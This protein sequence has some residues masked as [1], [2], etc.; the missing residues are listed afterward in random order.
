M[1]RAEELRAE[2]KALEEETK[3]YRELQKAREIALCAFKAERSNWEWECRPKSHTEWMSKEV[4]DGCNVTRR[5]KEVQL[6]AFLDH[7]AG[8]RKIPGKA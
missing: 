3:Q 6:A 8:L 1:S 7:G 5:M 2:L 4:F